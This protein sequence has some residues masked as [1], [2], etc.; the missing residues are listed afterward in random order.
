MNIKIENIIKN[1]KQLFWNLQIT[2]WITYAIIITLNGYSF[3]DLE[4]HFIY[5]AALFSLSGFCISTTLRYVFRNL[6]KLEK[7][8]ILTI[9]TLIVLIPVAA[10]LHSFLE[11]WFFIETY[12]KTIDPEYWEPELKSYFKNYPFDILLII[13]WSALYF[14]INFYFT[15]FEKT[16]Q[17]AE[18]SALAHQAQL[19][20]LRYQLNPH[21]LFNTLNAISTLVLDKQSHEA[22]SM[23]TKLSAFLRFSLVSQPHQKTSLNEELYAL[24]LYLDIEKVR[25]GE[26]LQFKTDITKPA[27]KALVPSLILQPLVENSIKYAISTMEEGGTIKLK[28]YTENNKLYITLEDDGP[29]LAKANKQMTITSSSGVGI[30]NTR[31]RLA[32]LYP[33]KHTF[34]VISNQP[35]GL[36]LSISLPLLYKDKSPRL[37][38]NED[39]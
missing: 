13:T 29:G 22:N 37:K 17:F 25:F 16:K 18:A 24:H 36:R 39:E 7:P 28:A 38:E 4:S 3:R 8:T 32:K 1:K 27:E 14:A 19:K 5:A 20:M 33:N 12:E 9:I 26:R 23:L 15:A 35:K 10:A 11:A 21:F 2:G 34:T 6:K 30:A 31:E